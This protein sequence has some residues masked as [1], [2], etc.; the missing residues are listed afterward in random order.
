MD[1]KTY[2]LTLV[3]PEE[4][5]EKE[6]KAVITE[7]IAKSGGES[8]SFDFWGKKDLAYPIKK[9]TRGI[10]GFSELVLAPSQA[11]DIASRLRLNEKLLRHLLVIKTTKKEAKAKATKKK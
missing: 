4:T 3:L 5:S 11:I 1:T 2:E 9:Q 10:Y 8:T 6:A 7:L